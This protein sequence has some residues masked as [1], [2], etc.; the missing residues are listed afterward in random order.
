MNA[1]FRVKHTLAWFALTCLSASIVQAQ[2]INDSELAVT[3]SREGVVIAARS[4]DV[5]P[6]VSNLIARLHFV[7]GQV[8]HQ[9]DLLVEL[10]S[11]FKKLEVEL[12]E[13]TRSRAEIKLNNTK[14]DLERMEK[15]KARDAIAIK[16]YRDAFFAAEAAATELKSADVQLEMANAVLNAQKIYAPFDGRITEPLY[17]ENAYV[18]LREGTEIATVIQLDPINVRAS[19]SVQRVL[20][21]LRAGEFEPGFAK[22]IRI[23]LKLSDGLIYKHKGHIVSTGVSVD[24]NTGRGTVLVSFPNPRGILRPGMKVILTGYLE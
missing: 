4:W 23:E 10:D 12:A 3:S 5:T 24:T 17:R 19:V 2:Q 21:R 11:A 6:K 1:I 14:D 16:H 20:N 18:D 15:L 8:V 7:E 22:L 13:V 9:G